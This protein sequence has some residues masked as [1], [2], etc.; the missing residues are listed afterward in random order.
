M[1]GILEKTPFLLGSHPT[2]VDFGFIGPFFRH[3]A[4]DP[5]P[6]KIMQQ[7]AP[8]VYEWAGRMWNCKQDRL[9]PRFESIYSD[10]TL[11]NS[12]NNLFPLVAEY[13]HY[14]HENALAWKSNHSSFKLICHLPTELKWLLPKISN[15]K[16]EFRMFVEKC[17]EHSN[18]SSN[19]F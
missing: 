17:L 6:R 3:F 10:G 5:T 12:W 13:L 19:Y 2:I 18:N 7:Q 1:Q 11:P 15:V 14:L 4:S 8:A 16:Q 9:P